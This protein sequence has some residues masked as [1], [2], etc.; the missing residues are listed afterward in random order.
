MP[1]R[2]LIRW[3][4]VRGWS[5]ISGSEIRALKGGREPFLDSLSNLGGQRDSLKL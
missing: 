2:V 3:F 4:G 1:A 5:V